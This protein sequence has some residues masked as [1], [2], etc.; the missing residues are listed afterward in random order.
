MENQHDKIAALAYHE[1]GHAVFNVKYGFGVKYVC[2]KPEE[3]RGNCVQHKP[4]SYYELLATYYDYRDHPDL[5]RYREECLK[6]GFSQGLSLE[7]KK[8]M[9]CSFAGY[10]AECMYRNEEIV[11]QHFKDISD[12]DYIDMNDIRYADLLQLKGEEDIDAKEI[13][14]ELE[15]IFNK[16]IHYVK[17][18]F[19][20]IKVVSDVLINDK[21]LSGDEVLNIINRQ[22]A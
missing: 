18:N 17:S 12:N 14:K 21:K 11:F 6:K 13:E 20:E 19:N 10:I 7:M 3:G 22:R 2:I 16:T 1:A 9:Y 4:S 8:L 5:K 15:V